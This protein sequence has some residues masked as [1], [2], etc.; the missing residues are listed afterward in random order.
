MEDIV[1]NGLAVWMMADDASPGVAGGGGLVGVRRGFG[2]GGRLGTLGATAGLAGLGFSGIEA[3]LG[4]IR[5]NRGSGIV[6][7]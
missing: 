6:K 1:V 7:R 2:C 5:W 3:D 4:L